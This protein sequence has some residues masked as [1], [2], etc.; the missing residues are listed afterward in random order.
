MDKNCE[1]QNTHISTN[2][3]TFFSPTTTSVQDNKNNLQQDARETSQNVYSR[4]FLA[5]SCL[6]MYEGFK[7]HILIFNTLGFLQQHLMSRDKDA[8][9]YYHICW[10]NLKE[11]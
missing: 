1:Y 11:K 7:H 2:L 10:V 4:H 9:I 8:F 6:V 3:C 5:R